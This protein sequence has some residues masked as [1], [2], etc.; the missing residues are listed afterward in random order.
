MNRVTGGHRVFYYESGE[1]FEKEHFG[2]EL[3]DMIRQAKYKKGKKS[4]LFL[5]IGSDRSTG[6]SLGPLTGYLLRERETLL[7]QTGMVVVGTLSLPV[8][9]VNLESVIQIIEEDFSDHVIVAV[10][11]SI[12]SRKNVGCITLAE[13]GLKPG[14]GVNKNLREVGDISITGVVSWG[15]RLEPLLLQNIRLGMVMDMA[16]CI[17]VGIFHAALETS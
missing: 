10:D 11:A 9:A 17:T 16:R 4:V 7:E 1:E 13:G 5:C 2:Q 3:A 6:D 12:G 8:H 15:S 14:Y